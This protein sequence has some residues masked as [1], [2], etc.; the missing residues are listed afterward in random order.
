MKQTLLNL[1]HVMCRDN[2]HAWSYHTAR[3]VGRQYERSLLCTRCSTIKTQL[4]DSRGVILK[5]GYSYPENY[6]RPKGSG[7]LT[8]DDRAQ[9]R[10][11]T[12]K[13]AM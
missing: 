11:L 3:K 1:N 4:L 13:E 6:V 7:R 5:T 9:L 12:L 10:I 2:A 8:R